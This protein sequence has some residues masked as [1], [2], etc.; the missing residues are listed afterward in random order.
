MALRLLRQPSAAEEQ[1]KRALSTEPDRPIAL[2]HLAWIA[3]EQR[4]WEDAR[5]WLDSAVAVDP[6]FFQAYAERAT[7]WL[8][9]GDSAG[10]RA[11]A[12]TAIRLRPSVDQLTGERTLLALDRQAR[13]VRAVRA[14]LTRLRPHAPEP[15]APVHRV[16]AWL[17]V[18][19]AAGAYSEALEF[20]ESIPARHRSGHLR[21][22]LDE[23]DLDAIRGDPRFQRFLSTTVPQDE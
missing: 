10:A 3:L 9:T 8:A 4:R 19:V 6:G 1:F 16:A 12:E 22:H 21:I 2:L 13:N 11:D 17:G 5:R 15:S 23:I 18:L 14:R 7:L 20:L